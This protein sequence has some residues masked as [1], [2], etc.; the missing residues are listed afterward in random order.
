ML[1]RRHLLASAAGLSAVFAASAHAEP[2]ASL[3]EQGRIHHVGAHAKLEDQ[4]ATWVPGSKSPDRLDARVW[5][6]TDLMVDGPG[7]ADPYSEIAAALGDVRRRDA[8]AA[9]T[10]RSSWRD[11]SRLDDRRRRRG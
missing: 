11:D 6:F 2:I 1:N 7:V 4:C 8:G 10:G 9:T 3:D 5:L